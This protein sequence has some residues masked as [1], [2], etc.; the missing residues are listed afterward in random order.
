MLDNRDFAHVFRDFK[1]A[2]HN[3][4]RAV[5]VSWSKA[6]IRAEP[7]IV[8]DYAKFS[9]VEATATKVREVDRQKR[10]PSAKKKRASQ[11]ASLR[12][13]GDKAD[14]EVNSTDGA[15]FIEPL[16]QLMKNLETYPIDPSAT[17]E[18]TSTVL[19]RR[20]EQII[21]EASIPI[22]H[23]VIT[24]HAELRKYHE[25]L[26]YTTSTPGPSELEKFLQQSKA[27][28]RATEAIRWMGDHLQLNLQDW[29]L[30]D[31]EL[32]LP[33]SQH[34]PATEPV[35]LRASE[36]ALQRGAEN[37]D[38]T[39]LAPLARTVS[40]WWSRPRERSSPATST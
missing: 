22:L 23:K 13:P 12:Q 24:T 10:K 31:H 20:A 8:A 5:A 16:V 28:T 17:D 34:T 1:E 4:G 9:A 19:R 14:A 35:M 27:P 26:W 21:Q 18:E 7:D 36:E 11:P 30:D 38:P 37:G 25:G 39:W 3:A 29:R 32:P 6:R 15:R 40:P 33:E 2:Y